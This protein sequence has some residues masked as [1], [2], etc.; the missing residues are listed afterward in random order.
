MLGIKKLQNIGNF[1]S[2]PLTHVIWVG[3]SKVHARWQDIPIDINYRRNGDFLRDEDL[4]LIDTTRSHVL[5]ESSSQCCK[6]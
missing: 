1:G 4:E 3:K 5:A 6:I 2:Y